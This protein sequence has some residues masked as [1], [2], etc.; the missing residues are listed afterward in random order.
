MLLFTFY[1]ISGQRSRIFLKLLL[2]AFE[3]DF[4]QEVCQAKSKIAIAK[5]KSVISPEDPSLEMEI[6]PYES[7][8]EMSLS[9]MKDQ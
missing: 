1:P 3:N 6:I 5:L 4:N 8:W 9:W 7:L 2:L